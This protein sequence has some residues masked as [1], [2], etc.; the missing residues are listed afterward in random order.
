MAF[1]VQVSRTPHDVAI[2]VRRRQAS[3]KRLWITG[4]NSG[5]LFRY[6]S[7]SGSWGHW[8]LPGDRPQ[9]YAVYV[10]D[11]DTVWVSDWG[12]NAILRFNPKPESFES[13]PLPDSYASVRQLAGRKGEVLG[14][15]SA[16]DKLF[17][18][19]SE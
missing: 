14:A 16:A 9:P 18:I 12:A 6:D 17:M 15:E 11:T 19:R 13:F 2:H 5:D 1:P 3:E 4:W 7:K 8:H 10:D